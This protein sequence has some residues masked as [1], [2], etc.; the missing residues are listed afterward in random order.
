LPQICGEH[1]TVSLNIALEGRGAQ[2]EGL[3]R[4][5]MMK[6]KASFGLKKKTTPMLYITGFAKAILF[7]IVSFVK[8]AWK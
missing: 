4:L 6:L 3:Q 2:S 7:H 1:F 5:A 8:S